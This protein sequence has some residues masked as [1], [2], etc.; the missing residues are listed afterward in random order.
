NQYQGSEN[1]SFVALLPFISFGLKFKTISIRF[2]TRR[3]IGEYKSNSDLYY[4]REVVCDDLTSN[5]EIMDTSRK[6]EN[7]LKGEEMRDAIQW[8]DGYVIVYSICDQQSFKLAQKYMK[9]ISDIRSTT[10]NALILLGNKHDLEFRRE[11][12]VKD[13]RRIALEHGC[14]FNEISAADSYLGV[15]L[16]FDSLI[17]EIRAIHGRRTPHCSQHMNAHKKLS[18]VTV[19]R[20]FGAVFGRQS[21]T[22]HYFQCQSNSNNEFD[23]EYKPKTSTVSLNGCRRK[24]SIFIP[25]QQ[26]QSLP[27][28]SL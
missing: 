18:L 26:K 1:L 14:Q 20:V 19:S 13:A 25:T 24:K 23:F 27:V 28:V 21:S 6:N 7:D 8:A 15:S 16:A 4:K 10:N 17:R 12:D 9:A 11:V 5:V 22:P 3:F 2:L